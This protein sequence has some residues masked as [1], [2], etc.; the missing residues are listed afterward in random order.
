M[1]IYICIGLHIQEM[2][3]SV[4]NIET[5]THPSLPTAASKEFQDPEGGGAQK[6]SSLLLDDVNAVV[7]GQIL[8]S[9]RWPAFF[10]AV[11]GT[12]LMIREVELPAVVSVPLFFLVRICVCICVCM[13]SSTN[14]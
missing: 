12:L 4:Y 5:D 1:Y 3:G 11:I 10:T 2:P 13:Q 6:L 9:L 8:S 7:S 14:Y